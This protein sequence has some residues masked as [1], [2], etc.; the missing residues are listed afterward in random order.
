M[1][2]CIDTVLVDL[3]NTAT[4]AAALTAGTVTNSGDSLGVRSFDSPAYAR[5]EAIFLQGS[6]T[7]SARLLSPRLHDNVTGL[8]FT[9]AESPTQFLLPKDV[10]QPLYSADTLTLQLDAAASSDTVAA[11]FNYYSD[12]E[13]IDAKLLTWEQVKAR[14]IDIKTFQVAVTSSATI[15]GWTDTVITT[16]EN[17]LKADFSYAVLGFETNS[18]LL[19]MGLKGPAT[20]NLR[21]C[22]PGSTETLELSSYFIEM[23]MR[24]NAPHIPAFKANDRAATNISVAANTASVS[25]TVTCVAARL[26]Q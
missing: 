17:Q 15:G 25:A 18:A 6:G 12:L 20:G 1:G 19:C 9:A 14:M 3:H 8:S 2:L 11:L 13:G 10:G 5:L 4:T 22:A 24:H 21:V 7:R 26:A 16:T 23:G